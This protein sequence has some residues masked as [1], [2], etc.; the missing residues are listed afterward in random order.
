MFNFL[1]EYFPI[2]EENIMH[3]EGNVEL[4]RTTFLKSK[5]N[6]LNFLLKK[7]YEW[8]NYYVDG[9][10]VIYELGAGTGFSKFYIN[11]QNIILTDIEKK[12]WI[13]EKQDALNLNI[14]DNSVDVFICS[15]MIH[16]LA[17]PIN[18]FLN[19]KRKLKRGGLIVI[20]DINTSVIMRIILFLMKHEG[21]SEKIDVF[22]K[23]NIANQ[24]DDP[25]SAN[26][27]IPKLLFSDT[28][29]FESNTGLKIILN[30][31]NEFLIFPLSGGVIAK[32]KTID[33]PY[34][35]LEMIDKVDYLLVWLF[36]SL[37]AFGRSVV[38]SNDE[39]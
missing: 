38:L 11:N 2:H 17:Y 33:I 36:P 9:K 13:D 10:S 1:E 14:K 15:H 27:S 22:D 16:H 25:W 18:F 28:E 4:A 26:C 12:E 30:E 32:T 21:Y 31:L 19:L 7:R 29:R 5:R 37:F 39:I 3:N 35:I 24:V 23:N 34:A 8:M 20:Q 6:N